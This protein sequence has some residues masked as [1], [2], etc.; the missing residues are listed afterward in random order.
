M[1]TIRTTL[2]L[3]VGLL[4]AGTA[5]GQFGLDKLD[6]R[7]VQ[8][9]LDTA[10]DVAKI[11]KGV[12]GISAEEE[13]V[14]GGSVAVEIVSRYGGLIRDP[15]IVERL[16]LIGRSLALYSD[17]PELKWCFGLL[18][19]SEVNAFSAPSGYVFITRGL[20]ERCESDDELAAVLAH[21]ISHITQRHALKIIARGEFLSGAGSI[22]NRQSSDARAV[23][24]ALRSF[25]LG[26][27]TIIDTLFQKG[28]DP[29]TEY[30]ADKR[31]DALC[32][33]CGYKA[34][35]L[36]ATLE[37]IKANDDK[38]EAVF[39]SHP[40]LKNRIKRLPK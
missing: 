16:N 8:K 2:I 7:K 39:S 14:I 6:L 20:Y 34:G 3:C 15:L 26:I 25:D 22:L 18:D 9:G 23:S 17:R 32:T 24:S 36:R 11:S 31:G 5:A 37:L 12:A 33:L 10:K 38:Q 21:E 40:S 28:F 1:N 35:S 29:E 13:Y 30:D 19:S 4:C 27:D